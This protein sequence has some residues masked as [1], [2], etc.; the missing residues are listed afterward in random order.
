MWTSVLKSAIVKYVLMA[1]CVAVCGCQI[2]PC[3][4]CEMD[5]F[6]KWQLPQIEQGN[7]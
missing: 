3:S 7:N 6:E 1:G 5:E 2:R 4:E